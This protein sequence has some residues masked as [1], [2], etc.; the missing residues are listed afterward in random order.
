MTFLAFPDWNVQVPFFLITGSEVLY[1]L[2]WFKTGSCR[3]SSVSIISFASLVSRCLPHGSF[4]TFGKVVITPLIMRFILFLHLE[5]QRHLSRILSVSLWSLLRLRCVFGY[6]L[7]PIGL[8]IGPLPQ[9]S[10]KAP[11]WIWLNLWFIRAFG[12]AHLRPQELKEFGCW[13]VKNLT[14]FQGA[15]LNEMHFI[16]TNILWRNASKNERFAISRLLDEDKS[17]SK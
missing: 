16:I 17:I 1:I 15:I 13:N 7:H 12:P 4:K 5:I 8:L 9:C 11:S 3:F 14:S 6:K 2:C 10:D